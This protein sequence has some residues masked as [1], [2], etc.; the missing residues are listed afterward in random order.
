[1]KPGAWQL[2]LC[3]YGALRRMIAYAA[4]LLWA[5]VATVPHPIVSV[6]PAQR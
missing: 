4:L 2:A 6:D 1:M 5:P 3:A